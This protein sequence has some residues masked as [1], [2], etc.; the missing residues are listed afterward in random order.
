MRSFC[1]SG[2]SDALDWRPILFQDPAIAHSACA[3]CGLVSLKAIRLACGH[4]LCS[5][6]HVE[7]SRQGSTCP[8]DEES[9]RDD[10]CV[11]LDISVGFIAKRRVGCW[12]K[13]NGCNFEGPIC[14]LLK[15]YVE[16]DFH[17][18]SCPQCQ[19]SV[20]RSEIVGHC[21]HGCHVPSVGPVVDTDRAT[22]G[23]E[24]IE[25]ASNEIKEALGKLSEDLSGLHTSLNLCREEV[26]KAERSS[27]EQLEAKSATLIEHLSR[28]HIEGPSPAERGLSDVGG[29][30]EKGC[31]ARNLS[32][33]TERPLN[34]TES[35]GQRLHPDHQGNTFH[36]YLKGFA[37]LS[38]AARKNRSVQTESPRHYLSG[39][40]MSVGCTFE[41]PNF[42]FDF[43]LEVPN[44][45]FH[46][47]FYP[48]S[49][50]SSL[51]RLLRKNV[52]FGIIHSADENLSKGWGIDLI[53]DD[54][55]KMA[56][57][58]PWRSYRFMSPW[59]LGDLERSGFVESDTLHFSF[60]FV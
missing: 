6:C 35:T 42:D 45:F 49:S 18:V 29:K 43:G 23:Y 27:K 13:S 40:N 33:H 16:C 4:M 39:Y 46:F 12:N 21:K 41:D 44:L 28:L 24:S 25:Q 22:R 19:V 55:L 36:W 48:E 38:K 57:E 5:E 11:R 14:G 1:V 52:T 15:H 60:E 58:A 32:A 53:D 20:L 10:D 51:E 31:Q 54:V 3:L 34:A 59:G 37:A 2:F 17:V 30:V 7:C 47:N 26:R 9:F 56:E 8:I 50:D